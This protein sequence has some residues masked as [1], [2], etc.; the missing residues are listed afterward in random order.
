[1]FDWINFNKNPNIEK[2]YSESKFEIEVPKPEHFLHRCYINCAREFWKKP[3][4]F[5][6]NI[7]ILEK[8]SNIDKIHEIINNSIF[9]TIRN[10]LPQNTIIE[11]FL[12]TLIILCFRNTDLVHKK[13]SIVISLFNHS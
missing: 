2:D 11:S 1:M 5:Y 8:Q 13:Y 3:L 4:L 10:F 9:D 12:G 6:D 7:E